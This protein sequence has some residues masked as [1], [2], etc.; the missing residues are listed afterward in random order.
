MAA[1]TIQGAPSI[2]NNTAAT[3]WPMSAPGGLQNG[4]IVI[5]QIEVRSS[6]LPAPTTNH[7]FTLLAE[8]TLA[9]VARN[10]VYYKQITDAANEPG[11]WTWTG[12]SV[13]QL[14]A[15]SIVRGGPASG[16]PSSG[17]L[18]E[19]APLNTITVTFP[20]QTPLHDDALVFNMGGTT[21]VNKISTWNNSQVEV[22]NATGGSSNTTYRSAFA[23]AFVQPL[24]GAVGARTATQD[25][26]GT[27]QGWTFAV[28]PGVTDTT[29]PDPPTGLTATVITE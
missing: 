16:S 18:V 17:T 10:W 14:I 19:G 24:A 2:N 7:G 5:A 11:T 21:T 1:P 4:D 13:I 28:Q 9:T 3:T 26:S 23:G 8:I 29:P 25:S 6:T 22:W 12:S 27:H 15:G 20:D